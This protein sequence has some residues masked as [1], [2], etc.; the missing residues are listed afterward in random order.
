MKN[1]TIYNPI[2]F[3]RIFKFNLFE[4]F[5]LFLFLHYDITGFHKMIENLDEKESVL[6]L[7]FLKFVNKQYDNKRC[8]Q[9]VCAI[10]DYDKIRSILIFSF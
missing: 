2:D 10:K 6:I 5:H 4:K 7:N 8:F 9:K 3:P 1:L